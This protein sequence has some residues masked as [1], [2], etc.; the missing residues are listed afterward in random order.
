MRWFFLLLFF[1]PVSYSEI[2]ANPL[3]SKG[4]SDIARTLIAS[5]SLRHPAGLHIWVFNYLDSLTMQKIPHKKASSPLKTQ[6][7][8]IIIPPSPSTQVPNPI[9]VSSNKDKDTLTDVPA[10]DPLRELNRLGGVTSVLKLLD[11]R[12]SNLRETAAL[13]LS[14]A[15]FK[16]KSVCKIW[17]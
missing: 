12:K 6:Q 16:H 14:N 17:I 5:S 1:L 4:R 2:K 15:T 8:N 3:K 10:N 11:S 7:N 9:S 13:V